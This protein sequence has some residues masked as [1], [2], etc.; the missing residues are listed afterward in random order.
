MALALPATSIATASTYLEGAVDVTLRN[1][2]LFGWLDK[3]G[4]IRRDATGKDYNWLIQFK[5]AQAQP[6]TPGQQI[7][8]NNDNYNIAAA[9]T[10]EWFYTSSGMDVTDELM[11]AGS[12]AIVNNYFE[13][14]KL[15]AQAMEIYIAKSIYAN[16]NV[17]S[18]ANR[19][20]G[21]QTICQRSQSI[22]TGT[23]DRIAPPK[24]GI[25][26][27]GI[28]LSLGSQGG[29][30]SNNIPTALQMNTNLGTDWPDGQGDP[31]NAYDG[32]SPRLYNENTTAWITPGGTSASNWLTNCIAMLSRANTDLRMNTVESMMP[33]I[34]LSGAERH[35]AIK[36]VLRLSFRDTMQ[37]D[38]S[39][40]LGY[41]TSL[42]FEGAA[43]DLDHECPADRTFSI[44]AASLEVFFFGMPND[45]KAR[46]TAGISDNAQRITG[47]IF[48]TYG[49]ERP[50]G[51]L[52]TVWLM[53]AGGNSRF[54]PRYFVCHK[55]WTIN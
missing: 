31:T 32:T 21:F 39:K 52:Q 41:Y 47:G 13:R 26:Y 50:P 28:D 25:T 15:L 16:A 8:F 11:N 37:H 24:S 4:R 14:V 49:P 55:D 2:M 36:D 48:A 9:V 29:S 20:I 5:N 23:A 1:R 42:D 27:A 35:Q 22:A 17:A 54:Q 45:T 53:F 19:I 18:G 10:P 6:Y 30:W 33:N 51:S 34:H 40:D 43:I 46:T 44:C 12:T 3:A 7:N 38:A